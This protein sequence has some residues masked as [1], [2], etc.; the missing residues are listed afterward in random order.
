MR[1]RARRVPQSPALLR[2]AI[3]ALLTAL[4][5][6]GSARADTTGT[7]A[8]EAQ[9]PA[10]VT[11]EAEPPAPTPAPEAPEAAVP[12]PAPEAPE[13]TIPV[14]APEPEAPAP[15]PVPEPEAPGPVPVPEPPMLLTESAEAADSA[16][17]GED[18]E[19]ATPAPAT[20]APQASA[21]AAAD[22]AAAAAADGQAPEVPLGTSAL[23]EPLAAPFTVG[24]ATVPPSPSGGSGHAGAHAGVAAAP[25]QDF[26]CELSALLRGGMT[27]GCPGGL[28]GARGL[29]APA[30]LGLGTTGPAGLAGA[31]RP[32]DL[33]HEG[34][35]YLHL[36]AGQAPGPAPA[37]V[38][39]GSAAG[40]S[41]FAFSA[42][43]T[44]AG[45]LLLAAPRAMRRLRLSCQ[46]WRTASFALIP[47]RPG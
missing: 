46:P 40:A 5:L 8:P 20:E 6:A 14:P 43:V 44:L 30:A 27:D 11:T 2:T 28:L 45:L 29:L 10:P 39:G 15:T 36:P 23:G 38:A 41:G 37:G 4:L 13:A 33:D 17:V 18:S 42:F 7:E 1:N 25:D 21:P 26:R 3:L 35:A 32:A 31:G 16:P 22:G 24:S 47:E 9:A 34:S 12:A 19:A